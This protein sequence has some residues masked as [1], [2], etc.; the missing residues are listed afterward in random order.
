MASQL[1]QFSTLEQLE[2]ISGTFQQVLLNQQ[3]GQG[4]SLLG[5]EVAYLPA[6]SST[7]AYGR[8]ES[9]RVVDGEVKLTVGSTVIGL[10]DIRAIRN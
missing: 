6:D 1:A 9:V 4:A 7:E 3:L 10:G 2:G 5:K 8:V